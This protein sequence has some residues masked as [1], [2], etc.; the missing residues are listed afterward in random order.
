[1]HPY[2][3]SLLFALLPCPVF[4]ATNV[5]YNFVLNTRDADGAPRCA[6]NNGALRSHAAEYRIDPHK[7]GVPG[8]SAGG[9]LAAD[10]SRHFERRL[11]P[12]VDPA[13]KVSCRQDF[14]VSLYPGHLWTSTQR[15]ELNPDMPVSPQ[16]PPTFL[17]H[18]QTDPVGNVNNSLA[19]YIALENVS[20]P[21]ELH[22]YAEG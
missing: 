1:M 14:A 21:V 11:Y 13:D 9:H 6:K 8:F 17:L 12:L 22:L 16:T 7:I 18:A 19:D 20:V 5:R 3:L 15:F 10:I 2:L 4:A